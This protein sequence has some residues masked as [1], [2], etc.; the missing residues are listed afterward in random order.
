MQGLAPAL[1]D[2]GCNLN[3]SVVICEYLEGISLP[4]SLL[5]PEAPYQRAVARLWCDHCAKKIC[6]VF[7]QILLAQ[8]GSFWFCLPLCACHYLLLITGFAV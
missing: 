8:V 3:E 2:N 7:F 4:D 5:Y 1:S 6:P